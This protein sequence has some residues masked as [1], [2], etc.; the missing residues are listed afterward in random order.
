M[1]RYEQ[2]KCPP[3]EVSDGGGDG[4]TQISAKMLCGGSYKNRKIPAAEPHEKRSERKLHAEADEQKVGGGGR[5]T[6]KHKCE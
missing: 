6:Q 3:H 4:D 2:D 1:Q 5:G